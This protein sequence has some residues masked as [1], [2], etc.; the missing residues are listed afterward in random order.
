MCK[1]FGKSFHLTRRQFPRLESQ[2]YILIVRFYGYLP[3][4]LPLCDPVPQSALLLQNNWG[5]GSI[6]HLKC[7]IVTKI[8]LWQKFKVGG[9][10]EDQD[11][12][13]QIEN[14]QQESQQGGHILNDRL[15]TDGGRNRAQDQQRG[16]SLGPPFPFLSAPVC[17]RW[18]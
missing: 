12:N 7:L 4:K 5:E 3:L 14:E 1:I 13:S 9:F 2:V 15:L 17:C 18:G 11:P 8:W 16:P 10:E 6:L